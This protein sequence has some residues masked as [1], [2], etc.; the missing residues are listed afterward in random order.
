MCVCVCV[1]RVVDNFFLFRILFYHFIVLELLFLFLFIFFH[2]CAIY[3][4]CTINCFGSMDFLHGLFAP[5][6]DFASSKLLLLLLLIHLYTSNC[7]SPNYTHTHS[8]QYN[9]NQRKSAVKFRRENSIAEWERA[10][11]HTTKRLNTF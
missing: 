6:S 5:R 11:A 8:T 2:L 9:K 4:T 3:S 1:P 10:A 7:F